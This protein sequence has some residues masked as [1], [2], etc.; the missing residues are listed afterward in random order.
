MKN[1]NRLRKSAP[2]LCV[3]CFFL[4]LALLL[5]L[6]EW[7]GWN[8]CHPTVRLQAIGLLLDAAE[9]DPPRAVFFGSSRTQAG[10]LPGRVASALEGWSAR[11]KPCLNLGFPR[12]NWAMMAALLD[13]YLDRVAPPEFVVL[14]VGKVNLEAE[15]HRL[16]RHFLRPADV[17]RGWS[18]TGGWFE[19]LERTCAVLGR[20]PLDLIHCLV[21]PSSD[22]SVVLEAGGYAPFPGVVLRD[23]PSQVLRS[24]SRER[25]LLGRQPA[26][27]SALA[28][29]NARDLVAILERCDSLGV[30]VAL[31]H[32]PAL[33]EQPMENVFPAVLLGRVSWIEPDYADLFR[34]E[35]YAG[36]DHLNGKGAE[37]FSRQVGRKLAGNDPA[38][39][40]DEWL[41]HQ[42][43]R[44]SPPGR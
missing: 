32:I 33:G 15:E 36:L 22:A 19:R 27:K 21:I 24:W 17:L 13:R 11:G 16:I 42:P 35:L 8:F 7:R 10:V 41:R 43:R 20:G 44:P 39:S 2:F 5:A 31:L 34:P 12:C 38:I 23:D 26:E 14:E 37:V 3:G 4:W 30:R 6:S 28:A 9:R 1:S 29:S 40:F 18:A 25:L